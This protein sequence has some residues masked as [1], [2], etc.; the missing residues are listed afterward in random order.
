ML[1][2]EVIL[3]NFM[4]YR[5]ARIP[6]KPGVNVICGP[7]GAGKSSILIGI[8]VALGQSYTERSKK[9]SDLVRWGEESARITL[10]LDNTKRNGRRPIPRIAKDYIKL[11]RVIRKDGRYWFEIEDRAAT[12]A[13]V[14]RLLA[15]FGV[16]PEN[17]LIIMHQGMIESFSALNPQERLQMLEEAVGLQEYRRRVLRAQSRLSKVLSQEESVKRLLEEAKQTLEYWR[18]QYEKLM[19]KRQLIM[20]RR[21]LELELAWALVAR[22]EEEAKNLKEK[23]EEKQREAQYLESEA[24][25]L[26]K[27]IKNLKEELEKLR[28][29][30]RTL[31]NKRLSMEYE[32]GKRELIELLMQK[33]KDKSE[34]TLISSVLSEFQDVGEKESLL[35]G[36]EEIGERLKRIEDEIFAVQ[37]K[38]SEV[39]AERAVTLYRAVRAKEEAERLLQEIRELERRIE[40]ARREARAKGPRIPSTRSPEKILD[41]IRT[42]NAYLRALADVSDEVDEIYE[43]YLSQYEELEERAKKVEENRRRVMEEVQ[44]RMEVW[45]S[46]MRPLLDE[47]DARYQAI[48]AKLQATGRVQLINPENIEEAGLEIYVGFKGAEPLPLNAYT[49]SGGERS[50]ATVAFLLALQQHIKSPFRA[51]DEYDVHLDPLNR[52]VIASQ[53][54]ASVSGTNAQY[55]VITPSRI[56]FANENIHLITIQSVNGESIVFH[57]N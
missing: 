28:Q 15:K 43:R 29:E 19:E 46:L 33:T 1:I 34:F 31:I 55:L 17:M 22:K 39:V 36:I 16:N 24:K 35:A 27:R 40:A 12:K 10:I 18:E 5:Y 54:V 9:L 56:S 30:W 20:K 14:Q 51:V 23:A 49:Q 25:L 45:R 57:K 21:H 32:R 13:E 37:E 52:Q 41:E 4:S 42:T 26:E 48:L 11:T 6:L 47:V 2:R 38:I 53:I 50:A 8:S 3:E 44:K 7:N